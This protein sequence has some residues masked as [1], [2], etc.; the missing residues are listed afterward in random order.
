MND[1]YPEIMSVK[2]AAKYLGFSPL[3]IYQLIER[4]EIPNKK[5]GGQYRFSRR[6]L[7]AWIAGEELEE[8]SNTKKV[9]E[10]R[11]LSRNSDL[12]SFLE[13]D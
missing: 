7:E 4:N 13:I 6:I 12:D 2:Q 1:E 3:K 9:E 10:N 11:P 8:H 5:I